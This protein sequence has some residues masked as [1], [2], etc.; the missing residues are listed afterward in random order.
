MG[1]PGRDGDRPLGMSGYPLAVKRPEKEDAMP[2]PSICV[3]ASMMALTGAAHAQPAGEVAAT[4]AKL[5]DVWCSHCHV[6][7]GTERARGTDAAPPLAS[8]AQ[9]R[10]DVWLRAFLTAPHGAMPD[11][12]LSQAEI[13]ALI[14]YLETLR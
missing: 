1:A 5:A 6:A 9:D 14:A 13:A 2:R 12:N 11:I 10:D 4:G 8:V 7:P 3:I